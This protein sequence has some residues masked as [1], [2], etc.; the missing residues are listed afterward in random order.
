MARTE[1]FWLDFQNTFNPDERLTGQRARDFYCE[2]EHSP[3]YDILQDFRLGLKPLRPPIA[4]FTGHRG[5]GK[6]SLLL[7]VLEKF[8]DNFFLVYFDIEHNLDNQK[9]NQIDLLYLLGSAIYQTAINEK[10][11]PDE[12]NLQAL[13]ESVYK[14]TREFKDARKDG[15]NAAELVKGVITF[16][17]SLLGNKLGEKLAEAM[18]KPF[19]LSSEVSEEISRK[20]EIEPQVQEIIA[21]V[22]LIIGD[23]TDLAKKPLLVVVDGLDKLPRLEQAR[24]IF[25]E[26]RALMGPI[27]RIIYTVP[28]LIFNDPQ[29]AQVEEECRGYFCSNIKLYDKYSEEP[30]AKGYDYLREVVVR[31]LNSLGLQSDQVFETDALDLLIRKSGGIMRW[32]IEMVQDASKMAERMELDLI[33]GAAA[34]RTVENRAATLSGRLTREMVHELAQVRRDKRPSSSPESLKL[35]HG[36]LIVTYRNRSTWFD[37]HPLIWD[38]LL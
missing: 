9:A 16:G 28:M 32:F 10:L 35:L 23:V 37:A 1:Q 11:R 17:A 6:S 2:R 22:N 13:V 27:C 7:R 20:R 4:F 30:Y 19:T 18:L 15:L 12:E 38:E 33:T 25:L 8:K 26:S 34:E 21:N 24:F 36:L 5:C 31:R 14:V 3:I 29:F